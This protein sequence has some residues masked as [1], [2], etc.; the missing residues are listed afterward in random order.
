MKW[1]LIGV[2]ALSV[3]MFFLFGGDWFAVYAVLVTWGLLVL[4]WR[5]LESERQL[6]LLDA[7]LS[8]I[9]RES[10]L[11]PDEAARRVA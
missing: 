7:R 1:Q 3:A 4:G 10:R 9:A 5:S 6:T 2:V 8:A 11:K